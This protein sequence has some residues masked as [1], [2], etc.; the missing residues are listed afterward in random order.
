MVSGFGNSVGP[1]S[2]REENSSQN[3]TIFLNSSFQNTSLY[4]NADYI[5]LFIVFLLLEY[6]ECHQ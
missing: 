3:P 5:F 1:L 6:V 2:S 4:Q